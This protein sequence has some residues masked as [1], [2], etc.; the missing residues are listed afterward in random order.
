MCSYFDPTS[1]GLSELPGCLFPLSGWGSSPLLFFKISFQFLGLPLLLHPYDLDVGTFK[2]VPEVPKPLLIFLSSCFF[3]LFWL[4]VYFFLLVQIVDLSLG[5]LPFLLVPWIVF[6]ISPCIVFTSSPILWPYS[7]I[8]V[9][10][11]VT[12]ILNCASDRLA[13]SSLLSFIFFLELWSVLS[14]G[15]YFFVSAHLLCGKG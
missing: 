1:L 8:S 3:I 4:N 15:P 9:S 5:F 10:I 14:F 6:F 12:S 7:T 11:L 13:I 2:V